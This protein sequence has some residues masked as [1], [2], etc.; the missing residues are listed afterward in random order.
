MT[1][2]GRRFPTS[3]S[4][5]STSRYLKAL[6]QAV[7]PNVEHVTAGVRDCLMDRKEETEGGGVDLIVSGVLRPL[8]TRCQPASAREV[9]RRSIV[10]Y[11]GQWANISTPAAT[12]EIATAIPN[13]HFKYARSSFRA[14][15]R[16]WPCSTLGPSGN[17]DYAPVHGRRP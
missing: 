14:A 9:S 2:H 15:G 13:P 16:S 11:G 8:I 12:C 4:T 1:A 6:Q 10:S 5:T 17:G 3:S 7:A